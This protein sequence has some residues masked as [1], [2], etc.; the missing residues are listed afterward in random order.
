VLVGLATALKIYPGV[1]I[2]AWLWRRQWREALTGLA[3]AVVV[4]G[5]GCALWPRS[6]ATY[7]SKVVFGGAEIAKFT[8]GVVG[9]HSSE[10]VNGNSVAALLERTPF[11]HG[12]LSPFVVL[13]VSALVLVF[14]FIAARRVWRKGHELSA[15]I[16]L[17]IVSVIAAPVAWDHYFVFAPLLMLVPFECGW[18]SLLPRVSVAAGL[19][20]MVPWYHDRVAGPGNW[21]SGWVSA[22]N[23]FTARNA[24]VLLCL[25]VVAAAYFDKSPATGGVVGECSA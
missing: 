22:V 14:G 2:V 16:V 21:L 5:M 17:L 1:F 10:V 15:L 13:S 7:F 20:M 12:S 25:G 3:S 8:G 4:T 18:R 9:S 23:I 11:S 19:L 24:L 6:A